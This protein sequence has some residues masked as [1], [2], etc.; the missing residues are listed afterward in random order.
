MKERGIIRK[1][2]GNPNGNP[3]LQILWHENAPA[4]GI[5]LNE[6]AWKILKA[7][8]NKR[9]VKAPKPILEEK[10]KTS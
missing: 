9:N 4:I 6:T 1:S 3:F 8:K 7:N 2:F 10:L 5:K